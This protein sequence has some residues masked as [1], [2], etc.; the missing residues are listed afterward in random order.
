M[1][2]KIKTY[3][4]LVTDMLTVIGEKTG[5][6]NFN[7]GSVVRT[8]AHA[9]TA[10]SAGPSAGQNGEG[11]PRGRPSNQHPLTRFP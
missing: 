10:R 11:R 5:L 1:S 7:V 4:E 6:T 9:A 2:I 3:P 8:T